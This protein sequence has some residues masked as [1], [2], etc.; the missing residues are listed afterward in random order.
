MNSTEF[1]AFF[2]DNEKLNT[3]TD[4]ERIELFRY[5]CVGSSDFTAELLQEIF[6]DYSVEHL[7]VIEV[8]VE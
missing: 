6:D 8:E 5:A 2:R 1:M 3:L 4:D 7:Q